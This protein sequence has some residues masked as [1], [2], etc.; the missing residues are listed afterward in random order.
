ME[1]PRKKARTHEFASLAAIAVPDIAVCL[2]RRFVQSDCTLRR[3]FIPDG[4][5]AGDVVASSESRRPECSRTVQW[6]DGMDF[7]GRAVDQ[8]AD[9]PRINSFRSSLARHD[10]KWKCRN[11]AGEY[12]AGADQ[13]SRRVRVAT[14]M[15]R[16]LWQCRPGPNVED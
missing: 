13:H 12:C 4:N 14:R 5:V 8:S 15:S 9:L 2:R 16:N 11:H 1:A 7:R 10:N 3:D 6:N